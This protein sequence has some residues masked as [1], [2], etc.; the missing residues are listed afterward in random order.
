[1]E[2]PWAENTASP[3]EIITPH[4]KY[5]S[6]LLAPPTTATA[7]SLHPPARISSP[8]P[9]SLLIATFNMR[10]PAVCIFT[11][12]GK[13]KNV[14]WCEGA[15][16]TSSVCFNEPFLVTIHLG[17]VFAGDVLLCGSTIYFLLYQS[18]SVSPQSAG[19]LNALT[20]LATQSAAPAV[21]DKNNNE[22]KDTQVQ[23]IITTPDVLRL[24]NLTADG[25]SSVH[26]V[27]EIAPSTRSSRMV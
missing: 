26:R 16:E 20:K 7:Q 25:L 21:N 6:E 3:M 22:I 9:A 17:T 12:A 19:I 24:H 27:I 23:R 1:M 8:I 13:S 15:I 4:G 18:K 14:T 11:F 10:K 5:D 2:H